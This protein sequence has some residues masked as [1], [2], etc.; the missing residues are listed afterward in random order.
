MQCVYFT[1]VV[2]RHSSVHAVLLFLRSHC[3]SWYLLLWSN[4]WFDGSISYFPIIPPLDF[5]IPFCL[6]PFLTSP[7]HIFFLHAFILI[8]WKKYMQDLSPCLPSPFSSTHYLGSV[9]F[10]FLIPGSNYHIFRI[11]IN[12]SRLDI[13]SNIW[14]YNSITTWLSHNSSYPFKPTKN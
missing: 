8:I 1:E 10:M 14:L 4:I 13:L 2:V 7:W 12:T 9:I 3:L 6:F 5:S 11:L